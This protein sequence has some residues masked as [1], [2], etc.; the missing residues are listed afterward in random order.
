MP[1]M[2]S[3][4]AHMTALEFRELAGERLAN[5]HS[6]WPKIESDWPPTG[7]SDFDLNP[8][9]VTEWNGRS[10]A[11]PASVLVPVLA[12]SP[13][14]VLLTRRADDL[15][16]HPGQIA[17][18]GGKP[19][20]GDAGPV[21][22]ALREAEEEIG[23]SQHVIEP[24]GTLDTYRTGTGFVVTP[25][26]AIVPPDI[27]LRPDPREVADVFEVPLEFLMNPGNHLV[28]A[29]ELAGRQRRF[30]AMGYGDYYIWG[31]TAGILR[32]MHEKL[33]RP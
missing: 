2:L 5:A 10:A 23:L 3:A 24:L 15:P 6:T 29:R 18:P 22:T 27:T 11:R 32:N 19:H 8:D 26:V 7:P 16:A 20:P 1:Q 28:E 12:R 31:A 13:L 21:A 17:F 25:I 9:A 33:F 14:T 30:Y 4:L